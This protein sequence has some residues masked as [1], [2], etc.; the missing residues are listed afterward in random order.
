M[1]SNWIMAIVIGLGLGVFIA[2]NVAAQSI[3][4]QP[5]NGGSHVYALHFSACIF[6]SAGLPYVITGLIAGLSFARVFGTAVAFLA[7]GA[8]LV[9]AFAV[10]EAKAPEKKDLAPALD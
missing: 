6:L 1:D 8:L 5:I 3:K 9:V 10:P 4:K 7:I 2:R